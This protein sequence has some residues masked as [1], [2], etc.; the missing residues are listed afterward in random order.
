MHHALTIPELGLLDFI[1]SKRSASVKLS[2][3]H[4]RVPYGKTQDL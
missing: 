2:S 3:M 4:Q 1:V